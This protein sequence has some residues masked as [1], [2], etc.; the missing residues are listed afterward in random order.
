M[1]LSALSVCLALLLTGCMRQTH[2]IAAT[3][4]PISRA[5]L[6][7]TATTFNLFGLTWHDGG[8]IYE[9]AKSAGIEHVTTV[10]E[11]E[12]AVYWFFGYYTVT[13]IVHGEPGLP[14]L[15]GRE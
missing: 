9:A 8:G 1:R 12:H 10:D 11:H 13:T 2:G 4:R 7:G 15:P 5:T 6:E 3:D 14:G